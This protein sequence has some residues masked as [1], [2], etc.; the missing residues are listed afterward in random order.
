MK[1]ETPILL[2]IFN[3]P[4]NTKAVFDSIKK[5]YPTKLYI[6]ADGARSNRPLEHQQ[7]QQARDI[8]KSIDWPCE[9][10]TLFR[11][12]NL[13]CGKGPAGA[14]NWFF[15][16]E[17]QGIILEDDCI[18]DF[19][20]FYYCEELLEKY[21]DDDRI[22]HIAGA[23]HNP[24]F[25]REPKY[26]YFFTQ[27]G[28]PGGWATWRRAWNLFDFDMKEFNEITSK[29]YFR[30]L[31]PNFLIRHYFERKLEQTKKGEIEGVWDYRWE[32]AK[33]IN[34]GLSITP[35]TNLI[36]N[37]GFGSDATHTSNTNNYLWFL[38]VKSLDLPLSHPPFIIR[39]SYS[40]N[41]HFYKLFK[42]ILKKKF[43]SLIRYKDYAFNG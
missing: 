12:E 21:K 36:R 4:E 22:M 37:I 18:P 20:F 23:N 1:F 33:L 27:L 26:S 32:F 42:S 38:E 34:S 6:A 9:V 14:I 10:K 24:S 17:T 31:Y 30:D 13:G 35:K 3:R 2:I 16:N 43:L 25:V 15:E 5:V 41:K 40:E 39:D 8:V 19:S 28:H 11:E 29:N 7:C